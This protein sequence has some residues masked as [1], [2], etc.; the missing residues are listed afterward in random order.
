MQIDI[1]MI[2]KFNVMQ[3]L[4]LSKEDILYLYDKC[5]RRYDWEFHDAAR[6]V[7]SFNIILS[8]GLIFWYR[9]TSNLHFDITVHTCSALWNLIYTF[10]YVYLSLVCV[11]SVDKKMSL[12]KSEPVYDGSFIDITRIIFRYAI[13]VQD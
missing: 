12:V 8:S 3:V 13:Q 2:L 9:C 5:R 4:M 11:R 7:I 1:K 6:Y 10:L